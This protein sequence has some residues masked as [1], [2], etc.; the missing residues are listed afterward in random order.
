MKIP[1]L[2]GPELLELCR[3]SI[4]GFLEHDIP[5][6]AAALAYRALFALF[7]FFA[8][9]VLLLGLLGIGSFFEWLIDQAH[10]ALQAQYANQ[11]E[12][13]IRQSLYQAQG[14]QLLSSVIII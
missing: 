6:Y 8:F 4:T 9:L 13:L 7:P 11:A 3:R 2:T 14:G 12:Q 5:T 10:S 1:A